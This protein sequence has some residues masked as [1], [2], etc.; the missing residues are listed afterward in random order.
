MIK[1]DDVTKEN[2][3]E[4]NPSWPRIPDHRYKI[5][6]IQGPGSKTTI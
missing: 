2:T 5:L 1:H 3:K 6:I 4:H